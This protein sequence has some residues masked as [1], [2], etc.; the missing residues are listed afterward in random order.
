MKPAPAA[1]NTAV[2]KPPKQAPTASWL[3]RLLRVG[4]LLVLLLIAAIL[5]L[6]HALPWLLQQQGI[7]FDWQRPS[8]NAMALACLS[9]N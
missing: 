1:V 7:D 4:I 8:G 3:G 2:N 6:P 9:Y 5:A